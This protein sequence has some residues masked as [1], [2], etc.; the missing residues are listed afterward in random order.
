MGPDGRVIPNSGSVVSRQV[1]H[2]SLAALLL[3]V[4]CGIDSRV[5][6]ERERATE[7]SGAGAGG[8][9][10]VGAGMAT[11]GGS[12]SAPSGGVSSFPPAGG[13]ASGGVPIAGGPPGFPGSGGMGPIPMRDC[14]QQAGYSLPL[15][16]TDVF[17][18]SG[19]YDM[20]SLEMRPGPACSERAPAARGN[21]TTFTWFPKHF[22][23]V[24]VQFQYPV[25]N[26]SGPGL[27]IEA[28]ATAI[29]FWVKGE[30]HGGFSAF[31][32]VGAKIE[33]VTPTG[34]WTQYRIDLVGVDYNRYV[35]EGGV[36]GAFSFVLTRDLAD[37]T[38]KDLYIDGI[39][40][41]HEDVVPGAGGAGAGGASAEG[42]E[43]GTAGASSEP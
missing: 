23:W 34:V 9:G 6:E 13:M 35:A 14:A 21:C 36:R 12:F 4:A 32:A 26:W 16:V 5:V 43:P 18:P 42:G 1:I 20:S 41:I 3:S 39:E 7:G 40:W 29:T 28:G 24:G 37:Y 11:P 38:Q 22:E 15:V 8:K 33:K 10:F 30:L 2:A 31:D 25:N 17:V 19:Y 27:C